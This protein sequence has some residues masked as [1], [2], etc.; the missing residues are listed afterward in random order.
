M[1][2]YFTELLKNSS[3]RFEKLDDDVLLIHDFLDEKYLPHL[4]QRVQRTEGKSIIDIK[5]SFYLPIKEIVSEGMRPNL[6]GV[7]VHIHEDT[8]VTKAWQRGSRHL[9]CKISTEIFLNNNYSGGT[10]TFENKSLQIKPVP[11]SLLMFDSSLSY[12]IEDVDSSIS[13]LTV[14]AEIY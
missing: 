3:Y 4:L 11:R 7:G 5:E 1:I 6:F 12:K 14:R 13:R 10:L 8:F 2:E 9:D